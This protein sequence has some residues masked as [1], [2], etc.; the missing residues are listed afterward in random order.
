MYAAWTWLGLAVLAAV[1]AC[2]VVAVYGTTSI[3]G[4]V[5]DDDDE[6]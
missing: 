6:G 1:A 3:A 5:L 4:A 2:G